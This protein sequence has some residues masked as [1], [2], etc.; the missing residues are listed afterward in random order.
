[1]RSDELV[2]NCLFD[3]YAGHPTIPADIRRALGGETFSYKTTVGEV[4]FETWIAPIRDAEAT[5]AVTGAIAVSTDV[6]E[7]EALQAQSIR[8]DRVT[9]L[10]SLAASVAHEV[11]NPLTY[12]LLSIQR[13]K[14]AAFRLEAGLESSPR[15]I[16]EMRT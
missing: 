9:A 5:S 12:A 16:E 13:A 4:T 11:N 14:Q 8:N 10:G 7:R 1:V 3:L 2:G 6:T 15:T